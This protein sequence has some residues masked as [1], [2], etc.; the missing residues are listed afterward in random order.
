MFPLPKHK[1]MCHGCCRAW[2]SV[3]NPLFHQ[4]VDHSKHRLSIRTRRNTVDLE[5]PPLLYIYIDIDGID[6]LSYH[7]FCSKIYTDPLCSQYCRLDCDGQYVGVS[8]Q[9]IPFLVTCIRCAIVTFPNQSC[10]H[11]WSRLRLVPNLL[12]LMRLWDRQFNPKTKG[13]TDLP[14]KKKKRRLDIAWGGHF[15]QS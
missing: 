13:Y 1:R 2:F 15:L 14:I 7:S 11:C 6:S 8:S 5:V 4:H 9:R 12:P 10:K 3:T